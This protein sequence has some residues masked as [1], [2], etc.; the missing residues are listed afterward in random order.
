M[1]G[2]KTADSRAV[3]PSAVD[4][5]RFVNAANRVAQMP[6]IGSDKG[7]SSR[8]TEVLVKNLMGVDLEARQ[9]IVLGDCK[10]KGG[11]N[12]YG[13]LENQVFDSITTAI[14]P[15]HYAGWGLTS[16]GLVHNKSG[17]VIVEGVTACE[18]KINDINHKFADV[19]NATDP[20]TRLTSA[21]CGSARIL[22]RPIATGIQR[23]VVQ[24]GLPFG[25]LYGTLTGDLARNGSGTIDEVD[26]T[27]YDNGWITSGW[28]LTAGTLVGCDL[29][30]M[31]NELRW[32]VTT[33]SRC[34][35]EV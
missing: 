21:T 33:A 15:Q 19:F 11:T 34:E 4:F 27:I 28:E 13:M 7:P 29:V 20:P 2:K 5:N 30:P 24:L 17:M 22:N 12:Y 35:S 3:I 32:C 26:C 18:V 6:V 10:Y 1:A 14:G 31:S 23:C 16:G 9:V 8:R 25:R